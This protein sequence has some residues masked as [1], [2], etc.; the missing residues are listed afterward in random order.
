[1]SRQ[2]PSCIISEG[3]PVT[4]KKSI[5]TLLNDYFTSTGPKLPNKIKHAFGTKAPPTLVNLPYTFEFKEVDE[6]S[7]LR[8]LLKQTKPRDWNKLKIMLPQLYQVLPRLLIRPYFRKNFQISGKRARL[9]AFTNHDPTSLNNYSPITILP[10]L[11]K[12]LEHIV[13]QQV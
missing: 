5:A 12:M 1:M 13:H 9:F 2:N 7:V 8:E 6:S 10:I 4:D 11:S 3:E